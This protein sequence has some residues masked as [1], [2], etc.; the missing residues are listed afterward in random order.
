MAD[1]PRAPAVRGKT[2]RWTWT[3]GPTQGKTHEHR[4]HD[5]G[6]VAWRE[7][8]GSG[9][10]AHRPTSAPRPSGPER[11]PYA[12]IEVGPSVYVVSYLASSGFTLTVV[13]NFDTH[14]LVGFASGAKEWHPLGGTFQVVG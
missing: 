5:D 7:A 10:D 6:T 4:F 9:S 13:L 14:Q 12:A 8:G 11:A 3:E 1:I 2:M